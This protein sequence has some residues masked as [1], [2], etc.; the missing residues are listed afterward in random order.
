DT[1]RKSRTICNLTT[2]PSDVKRRTK[3]SSRTF[4]I[5]VDA[6]KKT[7]E[8]RTVTKINRFITGNSS[9]TETGR[10]AAGHNEIIL[11]QLCHCAARFF[12]R[13]TDCATAILPRHCPCLAVRSESADGYCDAR[14]LQLG[15]PRVCMFSVNLCLSNVKSAAVD[16]GKIS[17]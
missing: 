7:A 11:L 6:V 15:E 8:A 2:T 14:C 12:C 3:K 17:L 1:F 4:H 16:A 9:F 10:P 13:P 5:P